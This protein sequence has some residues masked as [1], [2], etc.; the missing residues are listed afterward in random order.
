MTNKPTLKSLENGRVFHRDSG[1]HRRS[2]LN[3]SKVSTQTTQCRLIS[4]HRVS[5]ICVAQQCEAWRPIPPLYDTKVILEWFYDVLC[6]WDD[7]IL[8]LLERPS[9]I[10]CFFLVR[11]LMIL[12]L[13]IFSKEP[14]Q[15]LWIWH[16]L[17]QRSERDKSRPQG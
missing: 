15:F 11:I 7:H 5:E 1:R 3:H 9:L 12:Y 8:F 17:S 4:R 2:R 16:E 6:Y 10:L 14:Y 13:S